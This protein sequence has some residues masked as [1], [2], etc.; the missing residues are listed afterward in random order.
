V[1][2]PLSDA[3]DEDEIA[4]KSEGGEEAAPAA[5]QAVA[6]DAPRV[7]ELHHLPH[8]A[9][10]TKLRPA[11]RA[12]LRGAAELYELHV[13]TMGQR[14][15]PT[16]LRHSSRPRRRQHPSRA[17]RYASE[18]VSI[19]DPEGVLGLSGADRVIAKED[20]TAVHVKDLDV[21]LGPEQALRVWGAHAHNTCR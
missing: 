8:I 11:T 6:V 20:S 2:P 7:S 14:R 13:Y 21:V 1:P 12:F 10:W 19:L 5:A 15:C 16:L 9:M 18:M 3:S 4:G 17:R